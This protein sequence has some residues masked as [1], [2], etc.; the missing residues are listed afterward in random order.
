MHARTNDYVP[1]SF[2]S[3]RSLPSRVPHRDKIVRA[4]KGVSSPSL[5][6]KTAFAVSSLSPSDRSP[7]LLFNVY[8]LSSYLGAL[9]IGLS[10]VLTMILARERRYHRTTRSSYR[11]AMRPGALLARKPNWP[12]FKKGY[13]PSHFLSLTPLSSSFPLSL[14]FSFS[15]SFIFFNPSLSR[16]SETSVSTRFRSFVF[17][18]ARAYSRAWCSL[19]E[20]NYRLLACH[21]LARVTPFEV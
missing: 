14:F 6:R 21:P 10:S 7:P 18:F 4:S 5:S 12:A 13:K 8:P 17:D 2:G 11:R 1:H 15:L 16:C 19:R 3:G 9:L 20:E